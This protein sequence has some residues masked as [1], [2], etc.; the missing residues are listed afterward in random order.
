VKDCAWCAPSFTQGI[1]YLTD[2]DRSQ[3]TF[4]TGR[5]VAGRMMTEPSLRVVDGVMYLAYQR[6]LCGPGDT[7]A[8]LW[9]KT[10][11]GGH[12]K[13]E[14][15]SGF[16]LTPSLRVGVDGRARIAFE[17]RHGLRY[18]AARMR[19]GSFAPSSRIPGSA[20]GQVPSLA[21]GP[22]GQPQVAWVRFDVESRVRYTRRIDS[23]WAEAEELGPGSSVELSIDAAGRPHVLAG[24]MRRVVHRWRRT[25]G[26]ER[27]VIADG[28]HPFSVDIRAYGRRASIAWAQEDLPRGEWVTRD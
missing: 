20:K 9:F 13:K 22:G 16:G 18:A 11:R 1:W 24:T 5:R 12:W 8:P 15:V 4:G 10:D 19:R 27:R 23:R 2:K 3:G 21:L 17:G 6:C 25:D 14:L 26:W 7:D 28:I